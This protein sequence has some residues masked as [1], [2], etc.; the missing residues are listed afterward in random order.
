MAVVFETYAE[1]Y[2][3]RDEY[4]ENELLEMKNRGEYREGSLI[5]EL[6]ISVPKFVSDVQNE[7]LVN[8]ITYRILKSS[9]GVAKCDHREEHDKII[10]N[11][12]RAGCDYYFALNEIYAIRHYFKELLSDVLEELKI[13]RCKLVMMLASV[14]MQI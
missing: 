10:F 3:E 4:N 12:L 5:Y 7:V 14:N 13:P 1:I 11:V 2:E 6:E 8:A 9:I